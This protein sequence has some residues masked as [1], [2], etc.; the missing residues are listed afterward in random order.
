MG[1]LLINILL[2][3]PSNLQSLLKLLFA[4]NSCLCWFWRKLDNPNQPTRRQQANPL[5]L[6]RNALTPQASVFLNIARLVACEL[7]VISHFITKYQP[8][9]LNSFFF[10]GMLGGVGVFIFFT[11]SGF[12]ISYSLYQKL[13]DPRYS[14]RNYFVDRFSRIYSGLVPALL[15]SGVFVVAIYLT[16]VDYFAH[17]NSEAVPTLQSFIATL[18][19]APVFPGTLLSTFFSRLQLP[20]SLSTIGPF[21][22][23][24]V[25][26]TLMLEW[27]IYMFFGWLIIGGLGVLGRRQRSSSYKVMFAVVAAVLSLVMVGLAWDYSAFILIWFVG[28]LMMVA[29]S[30]P[31]FRT[32]LSGHKTALALVVL[33]VVSLAA[34]GYDAYYIFSFT[35]ESFNPFF[36]LLISASVF[37]GILLLSGGAGR[38]SRLIQRKRVVAYTSVL[39]GFSYTLFLIHYP[40]LLFFD[41]LNSTTNRL[42]MFMPILLL[43]NVAAYCLAYFTEKNHK[44]LAQKI[45]KVFYMAPC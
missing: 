28:V 13:G 2:K 30:N 14:F 29:V 41:G 17:L 20:F 38:F 11:I 3:K 33:F 26:W 7:V 8:A 25:L 12:L 34:V 45:K 39:A 40:M 37:L 16:N 32:K 44:K 15:F 18:G 42:V 23:N 6:T 21:G 35:H 5:K 36:G 43:I 10:G 24:A 19:M 31:T 9:T 22:F 1:E 27:W 4:V